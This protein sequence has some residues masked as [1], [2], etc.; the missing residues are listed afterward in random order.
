MRGRGEG[1]WQA[2]QPGAPASVCRP[3]SL[4][5]SQTVQDGRQFLK[6]VDPKLGVPLPERDYGG[7]CLIYDAHNE[8]DPFHNVWVGRAPGLPAAGWPCSG[9]P[10][11][12]GAPPPDGY[13]LLLGSG[14]AAGAHCSVPQGQPALLQWGCG[15]S[16]PGCG[17]EQGPW[18]L[19]GAR[20]RWLWAGREAGVSP[21]GQAGWLCARTLPWLVPEGKAA[22]PGCPKDPV[23]PGSALRS[24]PDPASC[25]CSG[26]GCGCSG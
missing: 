21:T 22:W 25:C 26:C 20:G 13:P 17:R 14:L 9:A 23:V 1:Q 8:S 4:L 10:V 2:L 12:T 11:C 5:A 16:S 3:R 19:Q 7:N 18:C 24:E 6:Y 15:P